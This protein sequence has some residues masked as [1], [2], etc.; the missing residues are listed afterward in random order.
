MNVSQRDF[1]YNDAELGSMV[2]GDW[3]AVDPFDVFERPF[4]ASLL[5][6]P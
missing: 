3:L 5:E 6:S 1:R 4:K 2:H